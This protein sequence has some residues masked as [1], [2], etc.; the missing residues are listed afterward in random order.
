MDKSVLWPLVHCVL[1]SA[2][3]KKE[4]ERSLTPEQES[5]ISALEREMEKAL[6]HDRNVSK[7]VRSLSNKLHMTPKWILYIRASIRPFVTVILTLTFIALLVVGLRAGEGSGE[8]Q[9]VKD[10]MTVFLGIYGSIIGFWF[11]EH[12]ATKRHAELLE[13]AGITSEK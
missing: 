8:L 9:V 6:L 5:A 1:N 3:E 2:R 10:M 13:E 7:E 4:K 12:T 11:G